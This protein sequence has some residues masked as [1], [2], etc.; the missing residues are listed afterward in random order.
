MLTKEFFQEQYKKKLATAEEIAKQINSNDVCCC[1]SALGEPQAI[2]DA[3]AERAAKGEITGVEHH[4]LLAVRKWKYLDPEMAGKIKHVAWFTSASA[5]AAVGE[6]RA[7]YMPNYYYEVP[8]FWTE[9]VKPNVAYFMV[10]PMDAHGYFSFGI[11]ASEG[12]AQLER[13]DKVFI[14]V[15]PN[16]PRAHGNNFL[17]ISEVDAICE[18]NQ[19]LPAPPAPELTENDLKIGQFVADRIPN[20]ACIQLGIGGM[21]N[22]VGQYL[23]DKKDLG[24]HSEMFTASMVDLIKAGAVNNSKKN[25]NRLRSVAS[26]CV[27]SKETY[28]Y[29]DDNPSVEFCPVSYTNDPRVISQ[30][31]NMI[32]INAC[33]EVDLVGQVCAE[34]VGPRNISGTGG[35]VDFIRGA[36]WSK[37]GRAYICMY[38]TANIKGNVV[39]KIT[40]SLMPGAHVTTS[41][42]DIDCIV[43]EYGVA[44]LKGKTASQRAKALIAVAHPDFREQLMADAKKNNLMV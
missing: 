25:I 40:P 35:Q 30:N 28:D 15:N 19:P 43:T 42:S 24:I 36:N 12:R 8:R 21:P 10:S 26:F 32:S 5:R 2:M 11:G 17:H 9:F 44:E 18:S 20:G 29:I 31:D 3:I 27:G 38:S 41:K 1:S 39:S 14:E 6:G 22:A 37:G 23:K 16:M 34:S 33:I 4:M 13:A 7:D